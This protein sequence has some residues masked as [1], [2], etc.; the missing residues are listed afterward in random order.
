MENRQA[1]D[2]VSGAALAF[3][4]MGLV[5]PRILGR[6]LGIPVSDELVGP[7]RLVASRNV[8][9]GLVPRLIDMKDD[10]EPL[11]KLAAALNA[12][13]TASSVLAGARGHT[14]KRG[15]YTLAAVTAGLATLAA[16]PLVQSNQSRPS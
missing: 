11:L 8:A 16:L 13:D 10:F 3:G 9:L 15:A 14:P 1:A 7:L 2:A 6:L 12:V 5:A 4:A